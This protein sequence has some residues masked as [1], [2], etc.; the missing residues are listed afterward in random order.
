MVYSTYIINKY[1]MKKGE[2]KI[3]NRV[4]STVDTNK[5]MVKE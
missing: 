3:W 2:D 5:D 4:S 1:L